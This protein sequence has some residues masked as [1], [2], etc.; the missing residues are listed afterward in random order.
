M[1]DEHAGLAEPVEVQEAE[2]RVRAV[3]IR[4]VAPVQSSSQ[5]QPLRRN[6]KRFRGG[7]ATKAHRLVY[8]LTLGS[9][10][11]KRRRESVHFRYMWSLLRYRIFIGLMTSDRKLKA[12]RE[13]SK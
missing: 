11:R 10:L 12:S 4:V 9:R 2:P 6:V 5:G 8:H 1:R 13:G 3:Q 7:L